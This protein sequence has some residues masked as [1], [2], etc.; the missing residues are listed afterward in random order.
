MRVVVLALALLA[1]L[2]AFAVPPSPESI[3]RLL[4]A[5]EVEKNLLQMQGAS[6]RMMRGAVTQRAAGRQMSAEERQRMDA[7]V[8]RI[9]GAMRQEMSIDKM[10]AQMARLYSETFTQEEVNGLI[11]FYQTPAGRAFVAKMP[12]VM[13][14]SVQLM[15]ERMDPLMRRLDEE[16]TRPPGP[17]GQ[18]RP[19]GPPG[20]SG[21]PGS[22]G[23]PGPY[24]QPGSYG[25][26]SQPAQPGQPR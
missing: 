18:Y 25:Q 9:V 6:E 23:Q 21:Q 14:K 4:T 17:Q 3:D 20:P 8:E 16:L 24:G 15:R 22:Y 13:Q 1:T 11:A 12:A 2:P 19:P 7:A 26:P 10:R 5:T